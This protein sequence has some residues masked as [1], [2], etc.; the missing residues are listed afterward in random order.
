[1]LYDVPGRTGTRSR[2][3]P[4]SRDRRDDHVVAVKDAVGDYARGRQAH[5]DLGYA[6]Y[7]GDDVLNL[8]WL[9]HGGVGLVSVVGH[10]AGDQLAAMIDGFLA[11]DHDR[12]HSRSTSGC[13]PR[14]TAIMGVPNYGATTAK[15]ALQLARRPRQP[16]RAAPLCRST[17]TEVAAPARRPGLAGLLP[18]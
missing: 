9:A 11:G 18:T 4:T 5:A 12:A 16:P 2:W 3:R 13:C 1:M 6:V 10:A 7:S 17:T 15:A 14:S 8:G